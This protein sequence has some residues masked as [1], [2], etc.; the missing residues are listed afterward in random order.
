MSNLFVV[1][2]DVS[3]S[4]LLLVL[5]SCMECFVWFVLVCVFVSFVLIGVSVS[6]VSSFVC[7]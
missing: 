1:L 6:S 4:L 3:G 2:C 7:S 5:V